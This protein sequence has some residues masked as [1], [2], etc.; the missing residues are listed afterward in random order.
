MGFG[1]LFLIMIFAV[2]VGTH[3]VM[4]EGNVDPLELASQLAMI[5][6]TGLAMYVCIQ[7]IRSY[8]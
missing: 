3:M 2:F 4:I 8:L 5:V 7:L 6:F 1:I